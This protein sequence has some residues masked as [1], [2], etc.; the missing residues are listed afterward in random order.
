MVNHYL[1]LDP[2]ALGQIELLQDS[3]IAFDIVGLDLSLY[4]KPEPGRLR[5]LSEYAGEPN[6][7]IK[8]T[9]ISMARMGDLEQRTGQLFSREV[10]IVG[11][12]ELAQRLGT[13]LVAMDIDWEEQLSNYTGDIIAHQ[14]GN[15]LRQLVNWKSHAIDTAAQNFKE[16][17]QEE[18]RLLPAQTEIDFFLSGVDDLRD[19][20]ERLQARLTRLKNRLRSEDP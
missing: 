18:I 19:H 1:S 5:I 12:T 15:L 6:C 16:Y 4:L 8:G 14:T 11:D 7:R 3:V 20:I 2:F 9:P 13:I 10:E 17:M